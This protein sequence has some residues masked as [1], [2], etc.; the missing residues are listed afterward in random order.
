MTPEQ[1]YNEDYENEEREL[2]E[3]ASN[4][5][6]DSLN[7]I[8][9]G[10][11]E[12]TEIENTN[13][14]KETFKNMTPEQV[15]KVENYLKERGENKFAKNILNQLNKMPDYGKEALILKVIHPTI[16]Q[17]ILNGEE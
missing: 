2:E 7:K 1:S 3:Y 16:L 12:F 10:N 15:K 6:E 9:Q 4:L 8:K 17:T 14:L 13:K 5:S 11:N